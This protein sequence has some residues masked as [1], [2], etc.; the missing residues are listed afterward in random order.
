MDTYASAA[1]Q[2]KFGISKHIAVHAL[3]TPHGMASS[4]S[5]APLDKSGA[6]LSTLVPVPQVPT[7][8]VT[9]VS[10]APQGLSGTLKS[11]PVVAVP[12]MLYSREYAL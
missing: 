7:G 9:L 3:P 11:T 10:P 4:V 6:V 12:D 8:M 5:P 1:V 2:D